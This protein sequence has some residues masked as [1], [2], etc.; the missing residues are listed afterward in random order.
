MFSFGVFLLDVACL[1]VGNRLC[2]VICLLSNPSSSALNG[3]AVLHPPVWASPCP[4]PPVSVCRCMP[5]PP[6]GVPLRCWYA[7]FRCSI[8]LSD[9]LY[10]P[11]SNKGGPT[12]LNLG[13]GGVM[14]QFK[15]WDDRRRYAQVP[16]LPMM[17]HRL[18]Y[19]LCRE[20]CTV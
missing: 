9:S 1:N 2:I 11:R 20:I 4:V 5:T 18:I 8:P 12:Y 19:W 15:V 10:V 3:R 7:A 6:G 13:T 14:G 17:S 16:S